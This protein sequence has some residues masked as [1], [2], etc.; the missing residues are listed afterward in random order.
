[1]IKFQIFL[2]LII[3]QIKSNI[4]IPFRIIDHSINNTVSEENNFFLFNKFLSEIEIGTP[5]QLIEVQIS[6]NN[7]GIFLK[8]GVCS[9][10][11]CYNKK[12]SSSLIEKNHCGNTNIYSF[13][14]EIGINES[15]VFKSDNDNMKNQLKIKKFPL[16]YFKEFSQQEKVLVQKYGR[17]IELY[18]DLYEIFNLK[19]NSLEKTKDGKASLLIGL[20][21]SSSYNCIP[22]SNFISLLKDNN[23]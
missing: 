16:L 7:Y 5:P 3:T 23:I 13:Y 22:R 20:Q 15:I 4:I 21:L 18:E 14:K 10:N 11:Q 2:I 6:G 8:E 17:K 19:N 9:S 12:Y 1:M